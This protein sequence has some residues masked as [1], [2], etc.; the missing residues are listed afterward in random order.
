MITIFTGS[1]T[2]ELQEKVNDWLNS[3][4]VQVLCMSQSESKPPGGT[5]SLG[6]TI[7][8]HDKEGK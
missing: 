3:N 2:E 5:W 8:W 4:E 1:S 6:L 7:L